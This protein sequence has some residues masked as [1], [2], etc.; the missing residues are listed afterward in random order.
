MAMIALAVAAAASAVAAGYGAY[1]SGQAGKR[2]GR[3][4]GAA[5]AIARR[6]MELSEEQERAS[7]APTTNARGDVTEYIPGVGWREKPSELT[8]TLLA[9]SDA[10]EA[11]RGA[12]DLPRAR[13]QREDQFRAQQAERG[14]AN[15]TLARANEG[16]RS[17]ADV[18]ADAV[19]TGVA[20]AMAGPQQAERDAVITAL[21]QGTGA[22]NTL[23][24][25]ARGRGQ[26]TRVVLE[27]ARANAPRALAD[28]D[29]ARLT[30]STNR[31]AALMSRAFAPDNVAFSPSTLA[32][33]LSGLRSK[34][35]QT[36]AY[37][38]AGARSFNK[39][40]N[41]NTDTTYG[42]QA[43]SALAGLER[44]YNNKAMQKWLGYGDHAPKTTQFEVT[45]GGASQVYASPA[46]VDQLYANNTAATYASTTPS[47]T[48]GTSGVW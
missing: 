29:S 43:S 16:T 39:P 38:M 28:A 23:I 7:L 33:T 47:Y 21:R 35:Q 17:L 11:R 15:A 3:A 22:E 10:E 8:Q 26:D 34:G 46:L 41:F 36:A 2:A 37:G 4:Q 12:E 32:D 18:E 19:R 1:E 25:N 40:E 24:N 30:D 48:V 31:Y 42:A 20:R 45:P 14:L 6:Q 44:L 9:R 5:N 13:M 27:E